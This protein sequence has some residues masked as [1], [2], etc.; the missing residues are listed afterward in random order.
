M[1]LGLWAF[2]VGGPESL[3]PTIQSSFLT[4]FRLGLRLLSYTGYAALIREY[5]VFL[6]A[7]LAFHR[8]HREFNGMSLLFFIAS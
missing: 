8:A 5:V 1:V 7:K 6:E 2:E 3:D 4:I